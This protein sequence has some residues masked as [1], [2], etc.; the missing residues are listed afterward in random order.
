MIRHYVVSSVAND[1]GSFGGVITFNPGDTQ[2]MDTLSTNSDLI[3]E[4]DEVTVFDIS[5]SGDYT[6]GTT[7]E[8]T[9]TLVDTTSKSIVI[10]KVTPTVGDH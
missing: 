2:Q 3:I 6:V 9:V 5:P 7:N 8:L 1:D 4:G 10:F